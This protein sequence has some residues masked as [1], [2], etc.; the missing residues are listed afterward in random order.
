METTKLLE[1]LTTLYANRDL[2][3]AEKRSAVPADVQKVLD[4]INAEFAPRENQLFAQIGE[5]ESQIKQQVI[6]DGQTC[7]GGSLQAVFAKG[8]TTWE[9]KGLE[10]LIVAVPQLAQFRKVGEPSVSIRKV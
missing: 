1:E 10:G 3:A 2:L 6:S 7:K 5:L 8:R 4:D 9:T